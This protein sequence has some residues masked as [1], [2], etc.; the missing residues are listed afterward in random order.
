MAKKAW[1]KYLFWLFFIHNHFRGCFL[2]LCRH[3]NVPA[4]LWPKFT[5]FFILLGCF[6]L[7]LIIF[8][9]V[10]KIFLFFNKNIFSCLRLN[11]LI[12]TA[13]GQSGVNNL[14]FLKQTVIQILLS[15]S[16]HNQQ[17]N[18]PSKGQDSLVVH[19]FYQIVN[20]PWR[21]VK[22]MNLIYRYCQPNLD[23][24][25]FSTGIETRTSCSRSKNS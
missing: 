3:E 5:I 15:L 10:F 6:G 16:T 25:L 11:S 20:A 18:V 9:F 17:L 19:L 23:F 7:F 8:L 4:F 14:L 21:K 13:L 2:I 12:Q 1:S 24:I 22:S